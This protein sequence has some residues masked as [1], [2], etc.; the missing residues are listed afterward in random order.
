LT[1][2]ALG[3]AEEAVQRG[4]THLQ[5]AEFLYETRLFPDPEYTFKHAL[6]HEVTY[7][8][9]LQERRKVLHAR[10]VGAIERFYP[11]RLTEHVEGLAHHA[12]RGEMWEEAVRYLHQAGAKA[13][14]RSANREAV[15][16]FE[17]ALTALPHLPETRETL[18][19][20]IDLRFDLRTSLF[21][22][23]E[24]ERIAGY[25]REAEALA[26]TLDDQ[27][28]LG[29]MSVYMCHNLWM[30]GHPTEAL[31]FGQSAQA[32]A[33]SL[34]DVPLQ[35]TGNLYFGVACLGTGDYRR[36]EDL[37]LKVLQLLEG[38]LSA[39]PILRFSEANSATPSACSNA[40]WRCL[41]SG[42]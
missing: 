26:R 15:S 16:C 32:L 38:E 31:G 22:L 8:T 11:D 17:Q 29:Q 4:L 34:G 12:V 14:A 30:T 25:P 41:A 21:P 13:L 2:S 9:L 23:G 18:E 6:T 33:E 1:V 39:S 3:A 20:A 10:I 24:F 19:Q 42:T 7:G 37:L 28:R 35:V 5:A 36:A 40:G 27:R